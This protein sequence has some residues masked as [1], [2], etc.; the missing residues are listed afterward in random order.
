MEGTHRCL[1][2]AAVPAPAQFGLGEDERLCDGRVVIKRERGR[3]CQIRHQ[4]RRDRERCSCEHD[5][6]RYEQH[7][8]LLEETF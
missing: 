3:G 4:L 6:G 8:V 7:N 5:E 2:T 1:V